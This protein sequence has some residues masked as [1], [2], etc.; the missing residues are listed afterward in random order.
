VVITSAG[1]LIDLSRFNGC[2]FLAI[3]LAG[4]RLSSA[5]ETTSGESFENALSRVRPCQALALFSNLDG[6]LLPEKEVEEHDGAQ[7]PAAAD[8]PNRKC[9]YATYRR[10]QRLEELKRWEKDRSRTVFCSTAANGY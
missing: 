6:E 8:P 1:L 10:Y 3:H 2:Q 4:V 7:R 5:A 9:P